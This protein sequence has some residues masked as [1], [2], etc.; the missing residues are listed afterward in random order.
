MATDRRQLRL[1]L[2]HQALARDV[3]DR[4][5]FLAVACADDAV[6]R[7]EVERLLEHDPPADFLE[8]G[9]TISVWSDPPTT[10]HDAT[11]VGRR[12]GAYVVDGQIGAGGMG[13]VYRATDTALGRQVA[14][15]VLPHA[16]S[17]D[18]VRRER[19]EREA[20]ALAAVNHPNVA[21]VYGLETAADAAAAGG[22][23]AALVM[24][25]VDGKPLTELLRDGPLPIDDCLRYGSEV[26]QALAA[27]HAYGIVHRDIKAANVLITEHGAKVLDFG[28]AKL[29]HAAAGEVAA[30]SISDA[31]PIVGTV[32]YMSPEQAEGKPVDVRSDIFSLGVLLYEMLCGRRPFNGD[33]ALASLAATLQ[34]S[35]IRLREV[36]REI[37]AEVE[38]IVLRCLEKRPVAR[39][40]SAA[41]VSQAL[42]AQREARGRRA[43]TRRGMLVAATVLIVLGATG[44]GVWSAVRASRL[45]WV[46]NDAV[47]RISELINENRRIAARELF[48]QAERYAPSARGLFT[49]AEGVASPRISF[50]TTPPDARI[51]VSDYAAA[52]GD[53]LSQW[54]FLGQSPLETERLPRWGYYRVRVVKEAY[55][56]AEIA[57]FAIS[58]EPVHV[59]LH[60][61]ADVPRGMVWIPDTTAVIPARPSV[62]PANLPGFWMDRYEVTNAEF[63]AFV[64]AGGYRE[65]KYWTHPFT[66]NGGTIS[67]LEATARFRDA[68]NRPGPATWELGTFPE[69]AGAVPVS[70][71]SWYEAAA[72][73]AFVG[74]D[75]PT[76]H[77]WF[78]AAGLGPNS[79]ILTLSNF[80]GAG[81]K[82]IGTHRGMARFGSYDMAGNVK[83]WTATAVERG[84]R[85]LLGGAWNEEDY[86]FTVPDPRSPFQR[87]RTFGFRTVRRL[88]DAPAATM[89]PLAISEGPRPRGAPAD[90]R[91][92][93]RFRAL[94]EYDR[95]E[96]DTRVER[97]DNSSPYWRRETVSFRA[98]YPNERV[99][100]HLFLP[101][102]SPPP[103]QVVAYL[104]GS[105]IFDLRRVE[106]L[107]YPYQYLLRSGRAV[108]IPAF[109]GTLE[110]GPS[111]FLAPR[112]ERRERAIRWS[113]DLG[114]SLD[115]LETRPDI[116][117]ARIGFLGVSIGGAQ[118]PRLVALEPR[119]KVAVLVTAGLEP[120]PPDEVDAWHYAPRVRVPVLMLNGRTDF[121]VPFE[122]GQRPLFDALGTEDKVFKRYE[123]GHANLVTRPDL[124]GDILD[125]FDR[126][127]GAV[128]E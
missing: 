66:E 46:E 10:L 12:I 40:D 80:G 43:L 121:L 39:Y 114:R 59:R 50:T 125:W 75:L 44:A 26:A 128:P 8:G 108:L 56:P 14:I 86:V 31:H 89:G 45:R 41:A 112:N 38:N 7:R 2:Y 60:A 11:L 6:L 19:L 37:P 116:D 52:A 32:A 36:R 77:E 17:H 101:K 57:Y 23:I 82:A 58:G 13:E 54:A 42:A 74:R 87:D 28:L 15:K 91:T 117:S 9:A 95:T 79:E 118:G 88:V 35:P 104:G 115:Y 25:L 3:D 16:L 85:S 76:L 94:H 99:I 103:Y 34:S 96:L 124:I 111:P 63:K 18:P 61:Q 127:L 100:A 4:H 51:Y 27:A 90:E 33:T 62:P 120:A 92:F 47:P 30:G 105:T 24:E 113:K 49:L 20:Q 64:D 72:Y 97:V 48:Q 70:G 123:G 110:R 84:H 5:E 71:V 53:D 98:A 1:R 119:V 93:Q 73:A 55:A 21:Q 81:P 106:D 68:T 83:E 22:A 102:S 107:E 65:Q 67:W 78:A 126:H 122:T 109:S 69:G 29:S